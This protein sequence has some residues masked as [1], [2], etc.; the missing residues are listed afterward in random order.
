MW[1]AALDDFRNWLIREA[2]QIAPV[3]P[4]FRRTGVARWWRS[5]RPRTVSPSRSWF[6]NIQI[7][8]SSFSLVSGV[9]NG[10]G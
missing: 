10:R 7:C 9:A 4:L 8:A 1:L 5:T 2:A 6:E 3:S